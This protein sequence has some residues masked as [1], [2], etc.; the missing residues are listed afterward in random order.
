MS[1]MPVPK[2]SKLID[3]RWFHTGKL[4]RILMSQKTVRL[5]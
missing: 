4:V 2:E 5:L 3:V 1:Y